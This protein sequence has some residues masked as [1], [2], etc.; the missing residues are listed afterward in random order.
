MFPGYVLLRHPA[1]TKTSYIEARRCR[2]LVRIL[3]DRWDRLGII[4]DAEIDGI[5]R[6][7]EARVPLVAH[8]YLRDGD[9]VRIVRGPLAEVEGI[10]VRTKPSKGLVV[11]SVELLQRSVAVEVDCT[12]VTPA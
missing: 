1:M 2:G 4:P 8:A 6:A 9:R 7:L 12:W 5:R 11:L 10:L 3:G